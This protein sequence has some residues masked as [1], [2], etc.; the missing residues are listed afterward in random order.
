MIGT[1]LKVLCKIKWRKDT[2]KF[3]N[4]ACIQEREIQERVQII[5]L[6]RAIKNRE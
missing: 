3:I 5:R 2:T 6:Q 4:G 1:D